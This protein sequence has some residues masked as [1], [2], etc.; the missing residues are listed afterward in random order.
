MYDDSHIIKDWAIVTVPRVGSH[1]LQERVFAHTGKVILKYHE[2][3]LQNWGYASSGL[4]KNYDQ[5]W[6]G[7]EVD[8]LKIITIAR[9]PKELLTSEVTLAT[10]QSNLTESLS[11]SM[12][13]IKELA[14]KFSNHYLK[15]EEISDIVIDYNQLISFPFDLICSIADRLKVKI[16]TSE[17][18]TNLKDYAPSGYLVSSKKAIQYDMVKKAIEEIDLSN[19]YEAYN[20]ILSRSIIL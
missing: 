7:L 20:K 10:K 1:Y 2:P 14:D 15:L 5:L 16:I 12:E 4:L 3:K 19:F 18:K 8:K 17:Y 6:S 13:E 11:L 9:D